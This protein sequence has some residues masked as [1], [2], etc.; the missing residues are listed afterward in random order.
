M[1]QVFLIP[2]VYNYRRL[3]KPI[4]LLQVKVEQN[5]RITILID[6]VNLAALFKQCLLDIILWR[7]NL[8][9]AT[10]ADDCISLD[11]NGVN[12]LKVWLLG[13]NC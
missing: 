13:A 10:V 9:A 5:L 2:H 6:N 1:A 7:I 4:T 11:L 3:V 8:L 12:V